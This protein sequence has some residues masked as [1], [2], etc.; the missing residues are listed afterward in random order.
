MFGSI[1][2]IQSIV[3]CY[4][5][6]SSFALVI[7]R[8]STF[9]SPTLQ[10]FPKQASLANFFLHRILKDPG[11]ASLTMLRSGHT[12]P[13]STDFSHSNNEYSYLEK[14]K[15]C[16]IL[17]INPDEAL[18]S[19]V[20]ECKENCSEKVHR[21]CA[22][23]P[24][25]YHFTLF[26]NKWLSYEE[27]MSISYGNQSFNKHTNNH[28]NNETEET[29]DEPKLPVLNMNGLLDWTHCI[30][31]HTDTKL[32][33]W[34]TNIHSS[35]SWKLNDVLHLT[36]YRIRG[37]NKEKIEQFERIQ[38]AFQDSKR[39]QIG[40]AKGTKIVLKEMGA[41]YDGKD[42]RFFRIIYEEK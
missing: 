21:Q 34:I 26:A 5:M 37:R 3:V 36:L 22:L 41:R 1:V 10:A 20:S 17:M 2:T 14:K 29:I 42:G 25:L 9:Q 28:E 6:Y 13:D 27:A 24:E 11:L 39:N 33:E 32:D 18:E 23:L 35:F 8:T 38:T 40:V 31:L 30:A 19:F 16:L 12:S 15:F 4:H 7:S